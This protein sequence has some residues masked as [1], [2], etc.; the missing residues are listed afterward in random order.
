[1]TWLHEGNELSAE[2]LK[3]QVRAIAGL[4]VLVVDDSATFRTQIRHTLTG[5]AHVSMVDTAPNGKIALQK[6]DKHDFDLMTLDINMPELGGLET[7]K[8]LVNREHKP[9]IIIFASETTNSPIETI[10]ALQ[11][12]AWDFILKPDGTTLSIEHALT[13][14]R[15]QLQPRVEALISEWNITSRHNPLKPAQL[16]EVTATQPTPNDTYSS[17]NIETFQPMAIVIASSTG[18]PAAL[19]A[20]L[21]KFTDKPRVPILIAQHMPANFTEHLAARLSETSGLEIREAVHGESVKPG[22]ILLCPG[23]HHMRVISTKKGN[24]I[25]LDKGPRLHSV[26]PAA[27][28]LFQSAVQVYGKH[29]MGFILTGMGEDGARGAASIKKAGGAVILQDQKTSIVWG[30]PAAAAELN[31]FDRI[32]PIDECARMIAKASTK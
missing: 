2:A 30:M 16:S 3:N 9:K 19:D 14:V 20:L 17:V 11:L 32:A 21:R 23:N 22:S 4:R 6:L 8:L 31:A 28:Y 18:G 29:L 27:D 5:M 1:M 15:E 7:L 24:V 10:D 26:R 25:H 12:G 13:Q